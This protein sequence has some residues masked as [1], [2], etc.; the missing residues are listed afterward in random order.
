MGSSSASG[1]KM[2]IPIIATK[3]GSGKMMKKFTKNDIGIIID[4]IIES[5]TIKARV[6]W[7]EKAFKD[8]ESTTTWG[9]RFRLCKED[10]RTAC[11]KY[12]Q[13]KQLFKEIKLLTTNITQLQK[14]TKK[15]R[16]N[17]VKDTDADA[18]EKEKT[19]KL[20]QRVKD[21]KTKQFETTKHD[22]VFKL[23]NHP[24]YDELLQRRRRLL[25]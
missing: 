11:N 2:E 18:Q 22:D 24:V 3:K 10:E 23:H 20:F 6:Q 14:D 13:L 7:F 1:V 17:A 5:G 4:V 19:L 25:D 12:T 16:Q 8:R 15:Q 21:E 9:D